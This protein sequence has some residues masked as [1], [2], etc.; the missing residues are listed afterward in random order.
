MKRAK[1]YVTEAIRFGLAIGGGQGPMNH[2]ALP[3]RRDERMLY[4]D[5]LI[6]AGAEIKEGR[7]STD[8]V[9]KSDKTLKKKQRI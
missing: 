3:L 8:K 9:L 5:E 6:E 4:G 7:A 1:D 2:V